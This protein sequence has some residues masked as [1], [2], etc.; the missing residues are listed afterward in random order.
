MENNKEFFKKIFASFINSKEN[1]EACFPDEGIKAYFKNN[2][3]DTKEDVVKAFLKYHWK[4]FDELSWSFLVCKK[5]GCEWAF[6]RQRYKEK[7]NG[8]SGYICAECSGIEVVKDGIVNVSDEVVLQPYSFIE[9]LTDEEQKYMFIQDVVSMNNIDLD[10][11]YV[12]IDLE[13]VT[14][15]KDEENKINQLDCLLVRDEK[16][17]IFFPKIKTNSQIVPM[18]TMSN[19]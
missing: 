12:C 3:P 5:C 11:E 1:K 9:N 4:R 16:Y 8:N 19:R 15:K 6:E 14:S 7:N 18:P 13:K 2:Y 10:E 17:V